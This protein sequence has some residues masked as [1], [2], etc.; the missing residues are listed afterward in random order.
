MNLQ[1]YYQLQAKLGTL[2]AQVDALNAGL[3]EVRDT[4]NQIDPNQLGANSAAPQP[5]AGI[6]NSPP[7]SPSNSTTQPVGQPPK[8][9]RKLSAPVLTGPLKDV[10]EDMI[11]Q[12]AADAAAAAAPK[13]IAPYEVEVRDVGIGPSND[14]W[15]TVYDA[16]NNETAMVPVP[17]GTYEEFKQDP[18]GLVVDLGPETLEKTE[19]L[20]VQTEPQATAEQAV[21]TEA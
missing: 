7:N 16:K 12:K 11:S 5:P 18:D 20:P 9:R 21:T 17:R 6:P 14:Y 19:W 10:V 13:R 8:Q 2:N 15:A 3:E 4:F 1:L